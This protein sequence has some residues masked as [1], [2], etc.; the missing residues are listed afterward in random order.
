VA[1]VIAR[2][3]RKQRAFRWAVVVVLGVFFLLPLYAMVE[4]STRDSTTWPTLVD[5]PK[6]A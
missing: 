3:A 4:F 1:G 5:W 2:R 6:L